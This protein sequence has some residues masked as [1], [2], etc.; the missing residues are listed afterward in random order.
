MLQEQGQWDLSYSTPMMSAG[1]VVAF[2]A[3]GV[4]VVRFVVFEANDGFPEAL[5][6]PPVGVG[7]GIVIVRLGSATHVVLV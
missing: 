1:E 7:A 6:P 5:L 2:D 3:A 4:G